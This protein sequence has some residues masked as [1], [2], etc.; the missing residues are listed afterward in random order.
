MMQGDEF[1]RCIVTMDGLPVARDERGDYCY[2]AG[3]MQSDV[4]AHDT[5]NRGLEEM[6][7]ISAY[8]DQMSQQVLPRRVPRREDGATA[9]QVPTMGS[10]RIPIILVNYTDVRF[11]DL[12]PL[13]TFENQFNVMDYSCLHYFEDQ[14]R[15]KFSP[16]FDIL[17]PVDLHNDRAYYG[18]N[19]AGY[20]AQLGT[21]IYDGCQGIA[22]EV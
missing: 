12:D 14:S 6:A 4:R 5:G 22:D 8:R 16:V 15:S 2:L 10:P 7:F 20:V 17:G 18:A 13:S 11:V 3:G 9:T 19:V 1:N 21:M